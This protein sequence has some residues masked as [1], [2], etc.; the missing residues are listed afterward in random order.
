MLAVQCETPLGFLIFINRNN[1]HCS[2]QG[3]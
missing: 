2:F 1:S 3:S